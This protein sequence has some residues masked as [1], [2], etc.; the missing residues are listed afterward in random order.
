MGEGTWQNIPKGEQLWIV[1]QEGNLYF[2]M[3]DRVEINTDGTWMYNTTIGQT[4]D[5]GKSFDIL[6]VL[7]DSS[8]QS[9]VQAW[10]QHPYD[11]QS[12]PAGMTAYSVETVIRR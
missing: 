8:A 5:G 2:P 9:T 11:L 1:V 3:V 7:A 10:Y 12:I 4:G 6:A